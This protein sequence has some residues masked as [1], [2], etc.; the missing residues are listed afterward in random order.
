[1]AT[2]L[3][4]VRLPAFEDPSA[5]SCGKQWKIFEDL[6]RECIIDL[7][8]SLIEWAGAGPEP[9]GD[10][11]I[12]AHRCRRDGGGDLFYKQM[13][14]CEAFTLDTLGWG[15]DHSKIQQAP[16]VTHIDAETARLFCHEWARN[17]L[18]TG[19]SKHSQPACGRPQGLPSE[20]IFVPLQRPQDYVQIHHSSVSLVEFTQRVSQWADSRG[21]TIVIKPHPGNR[22]DPE[23]LQCAQ[24]CAAR[25]SC[26]H[27][28]DGNV[29][30]LI[31][32]SRGVITVNSGVGFESLVHGKPVVT[33]GNCD[34]KWAA[35]RAHV[36]EL[37]AA[38]DYLRQFSP[39]QQMKVYQF[40][41][42]Y[43]FHHAYFVTEE[44]VPACRTR[45][46]HELRD[47]L[48]LNQPAA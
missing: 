41:Y 42:Y 47:V 25:Y 8:H 48:N 35:F 4:T 22:H 6:L 11:R 23:L 37:D 2:V 33:L 19:V 12:Y 36:E 9:Q 10:F 46:L 26:V 38:A 7:G 40:V 29:H 28:C 31:A 18:A 21:Q 27:L 1:M 20:F 17:A 34:Y 16:D 30:D 5:V 24:R 45:M 32:N 3:F 44:N 15:A 39:A 13:H 43:C 14:L